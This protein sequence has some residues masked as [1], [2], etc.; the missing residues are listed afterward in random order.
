MSKGDDMALSQTSLSWPNH[1]LTLADWETLP[2]DDLRLELV[3]GMLTVVPQPY[4]WHQR[5]GNRL[6]HRT[7]DQLPRH[8]VALSEVEVVVADPPL[9]IRVPDAL[10]TRTDLFEANPARF[11][12]ADLLLAVEILSD[13]TRRVDRIMKFAEY[14]EARI[15]QYW[16][17]D[18]GTPTTLLAYVLV[19]DHYELSAEHTGAASLDVAGH[20]VALDL[21]ALTTR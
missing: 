1:Q 12:A 8:L 19:E 9:T 3:E 7:D 6:T 16:I 20:P 21:D 18:L 2:E 15:P 17:V 13:G 14:A 11:A 10:V 5:A 4:S